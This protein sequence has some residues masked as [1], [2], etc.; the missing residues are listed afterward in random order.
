MLK[1]GGHFCFEI[2]YFRQ[3]LRLVVLIQFIMSIN[4]H[5]AKPL[6]QLL[7]RLGFDLDLRENQIQGGSLRL[8]LQKTGDDDL[9]RET[10]YNESAVYFI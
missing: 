4:Y 5:H 10:I 2:G 6:A 1:T 8:L 7:C 9:L 3:V